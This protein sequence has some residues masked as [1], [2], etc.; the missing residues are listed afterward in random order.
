MARIS[1]PPPVPLERARYADR[2]PELIH[3]RA[4]SVP[5]Y[6]WYVSGLP[7][8]VGQGRELIQTALGSD[9]PA[10]VPQAAQRRVRAESVL[11]LLLYMFISV[12]SCVG[13]SMMVKAWILPALCTQPLLRLYLLAEHGRCPFVANMFENTRT[14]L[15][16]SV[17]RFLAWNMPFHAEHH[18]MPNVPFHRLPVLHALARP[19][20]KVV[21]D[22]YI[23]F[24]KAYYKSL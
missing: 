4:E 23:R 16:N 19:H 1:S 22:G 20:L 24:N 11:V 7:F 21:G 10:F 3:L 18:A 17:V 5:G 6:L 2:D 14:T 13:S 8:W 12:Y 9:V 15:T